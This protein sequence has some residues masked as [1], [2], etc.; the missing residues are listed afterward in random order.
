[1]TTWKLKEFYA[2]GAV[3][4]VELEQSL[5]REANDD[6]GFEGVERDYDLERLF[7]E[8][9]PKDREVATMRWRHEME[10]VDIA[11]RLKMSRNAVD[12]SLHRTVKWLRGRAG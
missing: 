2:P 1:M 9:P 7:E 3:T 11:E 10:I 5:E 8:L 12:Q 6:P 4:E